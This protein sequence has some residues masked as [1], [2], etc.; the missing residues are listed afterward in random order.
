[1][2]GKTT[3][4]QN[5]SDKTNREKNLSNENSEL[6]KTSVSDNVSKQ[7]FIVG[8]LVTIFGFVSIK[9]RNKNW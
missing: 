3:Y 5:K 6:P 7:Y 2:S 4:G 9:L 8:L 1:M